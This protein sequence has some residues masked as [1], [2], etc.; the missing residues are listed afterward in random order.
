[1]AGFICPFC[2]HTMALSEQ[3]YRETFMSQQWLNARCTP[4]AL[5]Q[6]CIKYYSCPHCGEITIIADVEYDPSIGTVFLRPQSLAK[7]FPDY[8]PQ[9]IRNACR[10]NRND[11]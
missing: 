11:R 9:A 1:M 7:K 8:I 3:T 6:I 4:P 5:G 10:A 2:Q